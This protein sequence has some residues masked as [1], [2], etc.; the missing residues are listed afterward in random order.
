[1]VTGLTRQEC[2]AVGEGLP[3]PHFPVH[4]HGPGSVAT[5]DLHAEE[6]I[7]ERHVQRVAEGEGGRALLPHL[8]LRHLAGEGQGISM[9]VSHAERK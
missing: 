5:A 2:L 7:C 8:T 3:G 6:T 1:M 9:E 4:S